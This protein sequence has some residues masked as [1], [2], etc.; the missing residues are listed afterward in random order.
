M[1]NNWVCKVPLSI[2]K[3]IK[4]SKLHLEGNPLAWPVSGSKAGSVSK[5]G[6]WKTLVASSVGKRVFRMYVEEGAE[7]CKYVDVECV[8]MGDPMYPDKDEDRGVVIVGA[9]R[10]DSGKMT[11]PMHDRAKKNKFEDVDESIKPWYRIPIS[12]HVHP[13]SYFYGAVFDGHGGNWVSSALQ[14]NLHQKLSEAK[15]LS[16]EQFDAAREQER[17]VEVYIDVDKRILERLAGGA[18]NKKDGSTAVTCV[19]TPKRLTGKGESVLLWWRL[20]CTHPPQCRTLGIRAVCSGM[21]MGA[22]SKLLGI[23]S[24]TRSPRRAKC[25]PAEARWSITRRQ[26]AVECGASMG[27]CACRALLATPIASR[28]WSACLMC[29]AW[30]RHPRWT[31][32]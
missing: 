18:G 14:S 28:P 19:L 29:A 9:P 30:L 12:E 15:L 1:R 13:I 25:W 22:R 23:T 5:V 26:E 27:I 4:L 2:Q 24:P 31:P 17:Y 3:T 8:L 11:L 21:P 10:S 20:L 16:D 7:G 32:L 6:D